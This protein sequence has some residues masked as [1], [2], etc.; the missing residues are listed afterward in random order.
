MGVQRKTG[1]KRHLRLN[2]GRRPIANKYCEG[3]MKSTLKRE[4]KGPEIVKREA[5]ETGWRGGGHARG[6]LADGGAPAGLFPSAWGNSQRGP[7]GTQ[8]N[9]ALRP[10]RESRRCGSAWVWPV[11]KG[12]PEGRSVTSSLASCGAGGSGRLATKKAGRRYDQPDRGTRDKTT[13]KP[14]ASFCGAGRSG[15]AP[16]T[17]RAGRVGDFPKKHTVSFSRQDSRRAAACGGQ[18]GAGC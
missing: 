5:I 11:G 14:R 15:A 9:A 3:K 2:T 8:Q 6:S 4:S 7:R 13:E 16:Q 17:G 18:R 10:A 1:G 12:R